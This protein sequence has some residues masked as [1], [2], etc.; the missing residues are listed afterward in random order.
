MGRSILLLPQKVELPFSERD[1][2]F[3]NLNQ[4]PF[5]DA[6]IKATHPTCQIRLTWEVM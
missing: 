1:T 2:N 3:R 4:Q 6:V 5:S